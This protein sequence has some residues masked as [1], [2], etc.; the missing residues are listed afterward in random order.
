MKLFFFF[1][2]SGVVAYAI[3]RIAGQ[4]RIE[5]QK[6]TIDGLNV[7]AVFIFAVAA[8]DGVPGYILADPLTALALFGLIV[9]VTALLVGLSVLVFLRRGVGRGW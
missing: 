6:E 9:A 5:R 2:A 1:A 7:I 8:M 3:R 4:A